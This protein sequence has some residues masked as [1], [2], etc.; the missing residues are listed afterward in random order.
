VDITMGLRNAQYSEVTSGL[1]EGDELA[2]RRIDTGE[3]LRRQMFG[4]G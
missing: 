4:G 3:M 2:I 1:E